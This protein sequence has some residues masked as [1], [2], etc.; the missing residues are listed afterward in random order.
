MGYIVA[1]QEKDEHYSVLRGLCENKK[2]LTNNIIEDNAS[3]EAEKRAR[4][5]EPLT[6]P[7]RASM[8]R[9]TNPTRL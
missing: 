6:T 7:A 2:R 5:T 3:V 1:G 8:T 4:L 9:L